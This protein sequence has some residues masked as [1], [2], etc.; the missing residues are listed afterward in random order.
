MT[1]HSGD[2]CSHRILSSVNR[3][4]YNHYICVLLLQCFLR[5]SLRNHNY[6]RRSCQP[7]RARYPMLYTYPLLSL[8]AMAHIY[9]PCAPCWTIK[10]N[11]YIKNSFYLATELHAR[12]ARSSCLVRPIINPKFLLLFTG[13]HL[14]MSGILIVIRVFTRVIRQINHYRLPLA[15]SILLPLGQLDVPCVH[16][17]ARRASSHILVMCALSD[18]ALFATV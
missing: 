3:Q 18:G 14:D 9:I 5:R 4:I 12:A 10:L 2:H 11:V 7:T 13:A 1:M 15:R 6:L 16:V 17:L 8:L